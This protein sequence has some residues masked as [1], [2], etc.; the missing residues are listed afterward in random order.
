MR[1]MLL[2]QLRFSSRTC[3]NTASNSRLDA[4][5]TLTALPMELILMTLT[6]MLGA[7]LV[8]FAAA[9]MW[10][11]PVTLDMVA[12]R[13]A[14]ETMEHHTNALTP[15]ISFLSSVTSQNFTLEWLLVLLLMFLE[16]SH[17][18]SNLMRIL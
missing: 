10:D 5:R 13:Q 3:L 16:P 9:Q 12:Q 7:L 6:K 11:Q 1:P 14:E 4:R 15:G 18:T 17:C 2:L 8:V